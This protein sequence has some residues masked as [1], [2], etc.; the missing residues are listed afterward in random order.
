M[1]LVVKSSF[2]QG[3]LTLSMQEWKQATEIGEA[4]KSVTPILA[5]IKK[6]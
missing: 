6:R 4:L 3:A 2:A 5:Q 1:T